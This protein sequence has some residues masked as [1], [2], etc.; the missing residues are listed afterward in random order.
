MKEYIIATEICFMIK[1]NTVEE[2]E[3]VNQE[4]TDTIKL[5]LTPEGDHIGLNPLIR[6][7]LAI[8][9]VGATIKPEL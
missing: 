2:A 1:A 6:D 7:L 3:K 9:A 8:E 4:Y 5:R